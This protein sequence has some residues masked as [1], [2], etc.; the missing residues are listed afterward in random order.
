MIPSAVVYVE[1]AP[2]ERLPNG[3]FTG[4]GGKTTYRVAL[5]ENGIEWTPVDGQFDR[6]EK[7]CRYA[8]EVEAEARQ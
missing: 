7:A 8:D 5:T 2:G 1:H 4:R 3:D 6:P